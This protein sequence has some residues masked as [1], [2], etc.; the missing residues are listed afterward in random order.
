MNITNVKAMVAKVAT[1]GLVAAA[2]L[3]ASPAK[4]NA[5]VSFGVRVGGPVYGYGH[6]RPVYAPPVYG[7]GYARPGYGYYGH[8]YGWD[9]RHEEFVRHEE[10]NRYHGYR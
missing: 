3:V 4:A 8:P 9:R 5:Q 7:Y 6:V 2:F 1:V 10:W